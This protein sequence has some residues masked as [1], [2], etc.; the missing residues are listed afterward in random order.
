MALTS[1]SSV[2]ADADVTDAAADAS[3]SEASVN[4]SKQLCDSYRSH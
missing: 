2:K 1:S 4:D 3:D